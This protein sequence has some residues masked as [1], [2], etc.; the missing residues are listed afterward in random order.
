MASGQ[1]D[2]VTLP[3]TELIE[4]CDRMT[5]RHRHLFEV[6]GRHVADEPDAA[7]QRRLSTAAHRHAWHADLW[8]QRRPK[9]GIEPADVGAFGRPGDDVTTWYRNEV[10]DLARDTAELG[11]RIDPDLDPATMRVVTLVSADLVTEG[12]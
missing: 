6:L 11:E 1:G 9:I 7:T 2:V 3:I 10:A 4:V 5:A 8:S 12:V